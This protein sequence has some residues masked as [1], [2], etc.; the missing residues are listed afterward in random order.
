[1]EILTQEFDEFLESK[2]KEI[3]ELYETKTKKVSKKENTIDDDLLEEIQEEETEEKEDVDKVD[4]N[5]K[6]TYGRILAAQ[7]KKLKS[8]KAYKKKMADSI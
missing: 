7:D 2:H 6:K 8:S 4:F 1:M 5:T 3:E